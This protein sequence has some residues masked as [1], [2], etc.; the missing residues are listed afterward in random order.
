MAVVVDPVNLRRPPNE[1]ASLI[2]QATIGCPW[3]RCSFCGNYKRKQFLPRF[4]DI[5]EDVSIAKRFFGDRPDKIFLAD[6]NSFVLKTDWLLSIAQTCYDVFSNLTQIS[7]YGSARFIIRKGQQELR[8]LREAG[9]KK[10]YLGLETGDDEL[11]I[12]MNKGATAEEMMN[13]ATIVTNADMLLSVTVIQGLGGKGSW[14]RSAELT[15]NVLNVMKPRETRFHNLIVHPD[16]LLWE[17]V[18]KGDFQPATREEILLEMRELIRQLTIQTQI[19]TYSTNYLYPG[20]LD[21]C[22]PKDKEYMLSLL[23]SA[24]TSSNRNQYLQPSRMI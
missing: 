2:L 23:D 10:V 11:L 14:H 7:S 13:A 22:L 4:P 9:I 15:A 8:Q 17:Q 20:L 5:I 3:N 19:Y 16:S 6:A 18:E 21:G 12:Y 24:L 1:A